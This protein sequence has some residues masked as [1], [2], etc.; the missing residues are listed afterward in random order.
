MWFSK[1][2]N[3]FSLNLA[4]ICILVRK[5]IFNEKIAIFVALPWQ[6]RPTWILNGMYCAHVF[7]ETIKGMNIKLALIYSYYMYLKF[8]RGIF[9]YI[10]SFMRNGTQNK[11]KPNLGENLCK[12]DSFPWLPYFF[13]QIALTN[14]DIY[15]IDLPSKSDTALLRKR[16]C[17]ILTRVISHCAEIAFQSLETLNMQIIR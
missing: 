5:T 7:L 1:V 16:A 9:P 15:V 17:Y 11:T 10:C 2:F 12:I 14:L 6:R 4:G 8:V 13:S 3:Q